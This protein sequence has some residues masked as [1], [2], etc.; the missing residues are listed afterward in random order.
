MCGIA[1]F[2]NTQLNSSSISILKRMIDVISY[3]GPDGEGHWLN[4]EKTV[5][6]GHRR[7]SII[8]LSDAGHQPMKYLERYVLIFNGEIYNYLE[9]KNK[10]V[11]KGYSFHSHT[12]TEVLMALYDRYREN[13]LQYL[14]GM[15]AFA[16]YDE[17]EKILFCA[18][19]RFGE[20]PF[21]YHYIE[22][23]GFYF[24][25]EMKALWAA[26][27]QKHV[28][29]KLLFNYFAYGHLQ[30]P[31]DLSETFYRNILKLEAAHFL[32]IDTSS[33]RIIK[34]KRYWTLSVKKNENI[35]LEPVKEKF[36]ELFYTSVKRRLRSDVPVGSSLSGG[37]DSSL[38]VMTID[39]QKKGTG[40]LQKTFSARFPGYLKDEGAYMQMV[41]DRC[42]VEPHFT[43]PTAESSIKNIE[44]VF[45]H[46][47]EPFGSVS[48]CAQYEVMELAKKNNINVLL[49][50]QGADEILAGYHNYFP[51]FF[52]EL[53]KTNALL[54]K[55][56]I[57]AYR[58]LQKNSTINPTAKKSLK[59]IFR[60]YGGISYKLAKKIKQQYSQLL[61]PE[62]N[63]DFYH[64][65]DKM[66]F[67]FKPTFRNLNDSLLWDTTTIGLEQLLRYADR[68]SMAHSVE[69]RLPFLNHEL[70]EFLFTL[71]SNF[72]IREG[73]TKWIMRET[74][75][76]FLPT[77]IVW[78]KDK[79]GYEPPQRSWMESK[80]IK[81][82]IFEKRRL[83]VNR[84]IL[85][86]KILNKAILPEDP[87]STKNNA[88]RH[89]MSGNLFE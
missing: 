16:L 31:D 21:Y 80:E 70:V 38:V 56:E 47:E 74:F 43:F 62:F 11:S 88:W 37:L 10:L 69:V 19:D 64:E 73:W 81:E 4:S 17:K 27:I 14:D 76:D 8:D 67:H 58:I 35:S 78:R 23:N 29:E 36:K 48:I 53:R 54:Y 24:A 3:R 12:D 85:N 34:K 86:Q 18:R 32:K 57:S 77:E 49:D 26:G 2:I 89:W 1:G 5:G 22:D 15:F 41:I 20:K 55:S 84:K 87:G 9:L 39:E 30:N 44:K 13:C 50:G 63:R 60:N 46:Q 42:K 40:Q 59:S 72:K 71:P 83:L 82:L 51:V 7:L 25:S 52:R 79:I 33:A 28:S 68:N 45:Y 6:L 65:N 61:Y 66:M 75:K